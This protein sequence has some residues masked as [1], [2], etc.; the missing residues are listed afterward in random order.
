LP[1]AYGRLVVTFRKESGNYIFGSIR[2]KGWTITSLLFFFLKDFQIG[3]EWEVLFTYMLYYSNPL[4][5]RRTTL[6]AI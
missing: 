3:V 1:V 5:F 2:D 4:Q 6:S